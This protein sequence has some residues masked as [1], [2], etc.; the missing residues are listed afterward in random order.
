MY[1]GWITHTWNAIKGACPH[2]CEY[3]YC[4]KWGDQ[5]ELH[6]DEKELKTKLVDPETGKDDLDIF[7]GS[8][9]DMWA[10]KIPI[11]W[12]IYTI[13]H[14]RCF[15]NNRYLFQ[16]KNPLRLYNLH[17]FL[18]SNI[19]LGTT[20]ETNRYYPE[21]MGTAP[22]VRERAWHI[23]NLSLV[24]IETMVTLEPLMDFDLDKLV[25]I[26]KSAKPKWVNIGAN[27]NHKVK[28]PEPP[29]EKVKELIVE[30][31]K[32]TEVKI[33]KNLKRLNNEVV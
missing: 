27:T 4:K 21:I 15:D 23:L 11:K 14:C 32:I 25:G 19:V 2:S 22:S 9:C 26:I 3:C 33:K 31:K 29:A 7:C 20:I 13:D 10:D 28:L 1:Q 5:P 18:P 12:I 17:C 24:G 8:S 16:T 30:L 6:F